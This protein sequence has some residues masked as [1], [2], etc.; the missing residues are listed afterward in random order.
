MTLRDVL[1]ILI[2]VLGLSG[3]IDCGSPA[4]STT[5]GE[6][7]PIATSSEVSE[8]DNCTTVREWVEEHRGALPSTYEAISRFPMQYRK[9][10]FSA[11]PPRVKSSLWKDHISRYIVVHA[12][13][14]LE[15][16]SVLDEMMHFLS[17]DLY[18]KSG[19]LPQAAIEVAQRIMDKTV[20]A[21]GVDEAE[22]IF[23]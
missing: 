10:I 21:F 3:A 2:A 19:E 9:S 14:T 12:S 16:R 18:E 22:L 23:M 13:M 11:S 4:E 20:D 7:Q 15:Q 1:G 17:E 5:E 6:H 8:S